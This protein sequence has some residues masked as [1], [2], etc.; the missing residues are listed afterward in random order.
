[1]TGRALITGSS[2]GIGRAMAKRLAADGME[3]LVHGRDRA[4]IDEVCAELRSLGAATDGFAAD[5]RDMDA[6]AALAEWATAKGSLDAVI[7][8]AGG[9]ATTPVSPASMPAWDDIWNALTR[10]Q[11]RLTALTLPRVE[12]CQGIYLFICGIYATQGVAGKSG[13]CAARHATAGFAKS[14]FEE[15]RERGV[16]VTRIDPGFINT[17]LV[18]HDRLVPERM[19]QPEDIAELVA[20]LVALPKTACVTELMVR[21]ARSPYK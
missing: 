12:E 6:L 8:N 20:T 10:A 4:R 13:Y 3:I 15:V 18:S 7:H 9:G 11:M 16:R 2:R 21:P 14:L 19:I 5:L 1:M 17:P